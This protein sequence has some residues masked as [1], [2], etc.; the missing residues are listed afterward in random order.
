MIWEVALGAK[1]MGTIEAALEGPVMMGGTGR[2][3]SVGRGD[4]VARGAGGRSAGVKVGMN[5][6]VDCRV[7]GK[8]GGS[9]TSTWNEQEATGNKTSRIKI[10]FIR[11]YPDLCDPGLTAIGRPV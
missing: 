9:R 4:G 5:V 11:L 2:G 7:A 3:V 8:D 6:G 10:F 1:T